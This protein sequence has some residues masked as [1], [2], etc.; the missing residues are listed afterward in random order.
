[1]K[2]H[3]L[4]IRENHV[5]QHSILLLS[6][7]TI[8]KLKLLILPYQ[9]FSKIYLMT[10]FACGK[11]SNGTFDSLVIADTPIFYTNTL[12]NEAYSYSQI[13]YQDNDYCGLVYP[14]EAYSNRGHT[15]KAGEVYINQASYQA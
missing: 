6:L 14:F 10:I 5:H 3:L 2:I 8:R 4:Y 12:P 11:K 9:V 13:S 1:M 7:S 15:G